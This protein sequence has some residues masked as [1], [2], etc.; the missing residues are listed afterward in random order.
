MK[1]RGYLAVLAALLLL[2]AGC[3]PAAQQAASGMFHETG[4]PVVDEKLTLHA[5]QFELDNQ[6]VDFANMWFFQELEAK[7]NIHVDFEEVKEADWTTKLNLMFASGDLSDI[8]LRGS[9]DVE[10]YGVAQGLLV[11]LDDYLP[12]YMPNYYQRL[13]TYGPFYGN[14]ASDGHIYTIGFHI[15]QN[16]NMNGHWFINRDWLDALGLKMPTTVEELTDVL[17][18]FKNGD[19]NSNGLKDEIPYQATFNDTNNGL[20]NAFAFFGVPLNYETYLFIGPDEKI[21]MAAYED[22]FR[23]CLEW[24]HLL[25]T[26]GLMDRECISQNAN[27]W[28][29]KLN[30][31]SGGLFTYWRLQNTALRPDV[32]SQFSLMLPVSGGGHDPKVSATLERIEFG[33]ALTTA[34][35][36]IPETL[37]WLDAQFETET[38]MIS[39]NGRLGD[40]LVLNGDGKYEVAYVPGDKVLYQSVPVICGQFFAPRGYYDD[41]YVK[42]PHRLEK[43]GYCKRYSEAGVMEHKSY[44]YLTDIAVMAAEKNTRMTKIYQSLDTLMTESITRFIVSGVTDES[45]AAFLNA[46]ENVG[47]REYTALY[48][49][50]YDAFVKQNPEA[51]L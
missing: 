28:S 26:E 35:R 6:A 46:L 29:T 22:G 38:M 3:R 9:L 2:T 42:A 1:K 27:V 12:K 11:P 33:A 10:E 18:A 41:V 30:N 17:R 32:A 8:V 19:P 5:F 39:Q 50:A 21:K 13:S 47:V 25:Y 49:E 44:Q 14:R 51:A 24:L 43:E 37:R 7:T 23:Q 48:Q 40:T 20:Y 4:Y 45:F 31:Q 36:H 16:I 34:N 15:A